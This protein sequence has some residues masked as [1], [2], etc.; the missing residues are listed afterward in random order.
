MFQPNVRRSTTLSGN[1]PNRLG[2]SV[3]TWIAPVKK[4]HS[5]LIDQAA[6]WRAGKVAGS[7]RSLN[8]EESP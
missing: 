3:S 2:T 8:K 4:D 5:V 6:S 1:D 7:V